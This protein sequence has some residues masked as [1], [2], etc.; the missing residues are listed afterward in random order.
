MQ[1]DAKSLAF[2]KVCFGYVSGSASG[3]ASGV[4]HIPLPFGW[5][6]P[7]KCIHPHIHVYM[8]AIYLELS[9]ICGLRVIRFQA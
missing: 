8:Y 3:S 7:Q 2:L 1:A 9:R 5:W 4:P 6:T